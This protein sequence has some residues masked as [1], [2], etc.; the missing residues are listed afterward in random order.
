LAKQAKIRENMPEQTLELPLGE[1]RTFDLP[2]VVYGPIYSVVDEMTC[3]LR[4][5]QKATATP[6]GDVAISAKI[7]EPMF[8]LEN[9]ETFTGVR[10]RPSLSV[11]HIL[12]PCLG[13]AGV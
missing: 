1:P 11:C 9:G 4:A 13:A 7:K 10:N 3:V 5:A 6:H 12:R 2:D 8:V